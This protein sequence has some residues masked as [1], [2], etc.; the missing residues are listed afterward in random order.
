M[1]LKKLVIMAAV[2]CPLL[3]PSSD[4]HSAGPM[5]VSKQQA[6]KAMDH[7]AR[8]QTEHEIS[9]QRKKIIAE[10]VSA[11]SETK[12]ALHAIEQNKTSEAIAALERASG[13]LNLVLARDP[14]LALAP[15]DVEVAVS[16]VDAPI[17]AIKAARKQAEE[18]LEDGDVQK[19][20]AVLQ[21]LA[22]EIVILVLHLPLETYPAAISTVAPLLDQGKKDQAKAALEAA[23]NSL[24]AIDHVVPLPVLRAETKL[25][26]AEKLAQKEGRSEEETKSLTRLLSE[27]REQL[28]LAEILGYGNKK[29][30]Q[31][32]YTEIND[33]EG[34]S[35]AG[36]SSK[37]FFDRMKSH[38]SNFKRTLFG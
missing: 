6:G 11:L 16:E 25:S 4:S 21:G 32:F 15:I 31:Q 34:K 10:A 22:S 13:K 1:N 2:L 28:K 26:E 17:D 37:D 36:K 18:Y 8:S 19:A 35:H 14:H 27:A 30:Y 7:E 20:R 9:E 38:L 5:P 29:E 24:V 33:I 3:T 12:A 23:L